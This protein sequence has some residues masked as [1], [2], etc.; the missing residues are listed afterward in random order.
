MFA[1]AGEAYHA[2]AVEMN[3]GVGLRLHSHDYHE[4]FWVSHG[5]GIHLFNGESHPVR[6]GFLAFIRPEDTHN[7]ITLDESMGICNIS[8]HA[9]TAALIEKDL[10]ERGSFSGVFPDGRLSA[11][12]LVTSAMIHDLNS[13]FAR[14]SIAPRKLLPLYAVLFTLVERLVLDAPAV[15]VTPVPEWLVHGVESLRDPNMLERGLAGFY[16]TCG[17]C[18]EHVARACQI[19]YGRRPCDLVNQH[20]LERAAHLLAT[21]EDDIL[22]IALDCGWNN[23]GHFYTLF[24]AAYS[25]T[26]G[27]FRRAARYA[28]PAQTS[29]TSDSAR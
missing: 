12:L 28:L 26:P 15:A 2:H 5:S 16:R 24:N 1:K 4:V 10:Q 7:F 29:D 27:H 11:H 20:R 19:H 21:T 22:S 14:L 9:A 18:R 23:L 13:A 3:P 8:F 25:V 17:R 6:A